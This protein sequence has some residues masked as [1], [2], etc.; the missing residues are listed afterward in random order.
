MVLQNP[1]ILR[2]D[3]FQ[4]SFWRPF[5]LDLYF[6]TKNKPGLLPTSLICG[7]F[8]PPPFRP[9][10]P[11]CSLLV[12]KTGLFSIVGLPVNF[13]FAFIPLTMFLG[14]AVGIL[15]CSLPY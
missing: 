7:K 12:Y 9:R 13:N 8:F 1:K 15:E 3:T 4:L 2:F 10:L 5:G 14:F 11:S 6:A